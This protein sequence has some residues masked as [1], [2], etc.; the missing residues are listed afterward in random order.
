MITQLFFGLPKKL[1]DPQSAKALYVRY[2]LQMM[3][4]TMMMMMMRRM[5]MMTTMAMMMVKPSN[6]AANAMPTCG[7]KPPHPYTILYI[8][9]PQKCFAWPPRRQSFV[10]TKLHIIHNK[11]FYKG[12]SIKN[13]I[14]FVLGG[15]AYPPAQQPQQ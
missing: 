14:M 8:C 11:H 9:I 15:F 1:V 2:F 12:M 13:N 4:M 5:M 6:T 3:M 10:Q 7:L